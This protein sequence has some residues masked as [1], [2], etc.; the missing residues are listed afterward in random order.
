MKLGEVLNTLYVEGFND[1]QIINFI[2]PVLAE[3]SKYSEVIRNGTYYLF[4]H[5]YNG[6]FVVFHHGY[7]PPTYGIL[8]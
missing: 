5:N 3:E 8:E 2:L 4:Y 7:I 1:M 6:Y